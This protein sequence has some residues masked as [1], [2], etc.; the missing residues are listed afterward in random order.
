MNH[1]KQEEAGKVYR[2]TNITK[3]REGTERALQETKSG[4]KMSVGHI[5]MKLFNR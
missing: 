1:H 5:D 4:V 3:T 2:A